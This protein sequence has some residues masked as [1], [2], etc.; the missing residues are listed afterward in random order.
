[1]SS[2]R[3]GSTRSEYPLHDIGDGRHHIAAHRDGGGRALAGCDAALLGGT[4]SH[5]AK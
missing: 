4:T 3:P 1:M 5:A 2:T